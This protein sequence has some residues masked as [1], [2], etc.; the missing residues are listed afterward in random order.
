MH[1]TNQPFKDQ[2]S[3]TEMYLGTNQPYENIANDM[4]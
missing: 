2:N 3:I 4:A 1:P